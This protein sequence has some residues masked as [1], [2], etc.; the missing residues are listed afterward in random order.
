MTIH[1]QKYFLPCLSCQPQKTSEKV[2]KHPRRETL[3]KNHVRQPP[4]IG[5]GGDHV[6]SETLPGAKHHRRL[7]ATAVAPIAVPS[8]PANESA[9]YTAAPTLESQGILPP[10]ISAPPQGFVRINRAVLRQQMGHNSSAMTELY[11]GE[12]PL[13]QVRAAYSK[14][15]GLLEKMENEVAA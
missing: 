5:D 11:T 6:A 8:R 7:P 10:T 1:N 9:P 13:E 12:I 2:Q 14:S 3:T 15:N 4:P